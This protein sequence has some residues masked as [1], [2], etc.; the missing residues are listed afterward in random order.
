MSHPDN[1]IISSPTLAHL[2]GFKYLS[3]VALDHVIPHL[4]GPNIEHVAKKE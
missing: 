2:Q 3:A 1:S 4:N